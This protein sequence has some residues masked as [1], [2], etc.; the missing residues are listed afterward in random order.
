MILLITAAALASPGRAT[1]TLTVA[2]T[3]KTTPVLVRAAGEL[4]LMRHLAGTAEVGQLPGPHRFAVGVGPVLEVESRWVRVGLVAMPE[5]TGQG[6]LQARGGVRA[7]WLAFWGLS[8]TARC[9]TVWHGGSRG[10]GGAL[11]APELGGGLSLR[12]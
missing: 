8:L 12:L 1:G 11:G 5:L 9:D 10:R 7:S 6:A 3:P 4:G 2:T